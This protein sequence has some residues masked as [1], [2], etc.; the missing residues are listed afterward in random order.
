MY[1]RPRKEKGEM[2]QKMKKNQKQSTKNEKDPKKSTKKKS[3]K[4]MLMA[5]EYLNI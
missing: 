5:L 4:R 2:H 3:Y 1:I